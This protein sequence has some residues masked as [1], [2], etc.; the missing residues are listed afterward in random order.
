MGAPRAPLLTLI[1]PAHLRVELSA[2]E[3]LHAGVAL[4]QRAV[5]VAESAPG[6][7]MAGIVSFVAERHGF[8][9]RNVQSRDERSRVSYRVQ[10]RVDSPPPFLKPGMFVEVTF[11]EAQ[12]PAARPQPRQAALQ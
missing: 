10:V 9:P 3:R 1:D 11:P 12:P 4:G 6:A 7:P 5:V 8:T 2:D